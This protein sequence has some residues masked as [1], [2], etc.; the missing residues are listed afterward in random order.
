MQRA[1]T[2]KV[3]GR[4]CGALLVDGALV[5][6][7][8]LLLPFAPQLDV[9][10]GDPRVSFL[11][12]WAYAALCSFLYRVPFEGLLGWTPGKK[13]FGI[14]VIDERTGRKPGL[15]RAFL[16][17]LL[18]P[19]DDPFGFYLPGWLVAMLSERRKRLG[20]WVAGTVVVGEREP[21]AWRPHRPA[22]DDRP[23]AEEERALEARRAAGRLGEQ[24]VSERLARLPSL[25][26]YYVFSGLRDE[27]ARGIGDIDHLVVGPSGLVLVETKAD[28]GTLTLRDDGPI[29]VGGEP[30]HR[31]AVNQARRQMFALDA[32]L[33]L[34]DPSFRPAASAGEALGA[35]GRHWLL[36]FPRARRKAAERTGERVGKQVATLPELLQ[37]IRAYDDSVLD[38]ATVDLLAAKIAEYY[39]KSP[40]AVPSGRETP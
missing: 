40:D 27:R 12:V 22:A 1:T 32:F 24:M 34:P 8:A 28:R 35:G 4:R 23:R 20:D 18:R 39:G 30:L 10:G 7:A 21:V 3:M 37:R 17:T 36:C 38:R 9:G 6:L 15:F 31:D 2:A 5:S 16:R 11:L 19:L 33:E 13:I 14:R 25:G 29:L 26:H